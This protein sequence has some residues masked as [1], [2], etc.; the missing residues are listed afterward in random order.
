MLVMSLII[1]FLLLVVLLI[2]LQEQAFAGGPLEVRKGKALSYGKR[3]VIYRYD[4]GK[5]GKLSNEEAVALVE[6]LFS[7][8]EEV[9][10]ATI[11]FRQDA[12]GF[13]SFDIN[14]N[15]FKPILQPRTDKDL[16]GFT[17]IVFDEDGTLLD[18]YLGEG[19]GNNAVG[20]GGPVVLKK[21]NRFSIPESQIVLN[22]RFINGIDTTDDREV[23]I[24]LFKK[25]ILHEIGHAIGLDHSQLNVEALESSSPKEIKN[26]VPLMFPKGVSDVLEIMQD[27]ASALSYLYPNKAELINFGTIE[28]KVLREDNTPVL[29]A[30]VVLRNTNNPQIEA[31]S[32]VSDFLANKTGSYIFFAVPPGSYT[33][34]VESINSTF[35]STS[36]AGPK[37]GPYTKNSNDQSSQNPV[38]KGF[39]T[40]PN[41][42]ATADKS[43]AQVVTI[44]ANQALKNL[45]IIAK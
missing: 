35:V 13:L 45:N 22:G 36:S 11:K 5:L 10:T 16:N 26:S 19:G 40:G 43:M 4:K 32:C 37:V 28:G 39:Y 12:S 42:K 18:A 25:A 20:I 21:G 8:W 2:Y 17:P 24:Q 29:G 41:Q 1:R 44:E 27:D 9:K 33:I 14:A 6:E 30:N 7:T 31:I 38:L 15:N 34:E 23:S 3:P